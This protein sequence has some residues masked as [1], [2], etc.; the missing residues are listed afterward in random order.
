MSAGSQSFGYDARG[1]LTSD[2]TNGY[3]YTSENLLRTGP[4]GALLGYEF[5]EF[6]GHYTKYTN[7]GD[8][9]LNSPTLSPAG[10]V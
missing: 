8:T 6:R 3:S 1:N 10:R 7:S 5:R 4:G 9:I 2:G